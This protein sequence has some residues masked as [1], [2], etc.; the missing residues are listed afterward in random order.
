MGSEYEVGQ[1]LVRLIDDKE[2]ISFD[3]NSMLYSLLFLA[4]RDYPIKEV[5]GR[6]IYLYKDMITKNI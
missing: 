6:D 2:K 3:K 4:E 5:V 1:Y